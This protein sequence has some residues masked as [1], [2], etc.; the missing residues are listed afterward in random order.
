M[1]ING[2]EVMI[3]FAFFAATGVRVATELGAGNGKAAKFTSQVSAITSLI[4]GISFCTLINL[5]SS[6]LAPFNLFSQGSRWLRM[7]N[8][9]CYYIIGL[10]L[11][12]AL[13]WLFHLGVPGIW[14]GMI[15]GTAIQ[16]L[17]LIISTTKELGVWF[18]YILS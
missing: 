4:I 5:H 2:W 13:G 6:W 16:T 11:G 17:I 10:P 12:A 14:S 18:T 3:P 7:A 8:I 9:G 15:G 1:S